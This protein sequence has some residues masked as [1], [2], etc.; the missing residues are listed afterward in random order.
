M[1]TEETILLISENRYEVN[2]S[3]SISTFKPIPHAQVG[4]NSLKKFIKGGQVVRLQHTELGGYLT[5]DDLDFTDDQLAEV[6]VRSFN[7]DKFDIEATTS[8]DLFEVEIAH[9][10]DRGQI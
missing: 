6:Y 5:S 1:L 4:E 8:G 7:G 10:K 2:C 9:N 3:T